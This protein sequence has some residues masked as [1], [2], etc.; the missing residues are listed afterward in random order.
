LVKSSA[1][2]TSTNAVLR[3]KTVDTGN[4]QSPLPPG[5]SFFTPF[6]GETLEYGDKGPLRFG[7]ERYAKYGPVFKTNLWGGDLYMVCTMDLF[8]AIMA[9]DTKLVNFSVAGT[10]GKLQGDFVTK[11]LSNKDG[12]R[13]PFRRSLLIAVTNEALAGYMPSISKIALSNLDALARQDKWEL[14]QETRKWGMEFANSLLAGLSD[15][16]EAD[17]KKLRDDLALFFDGLFTFDVDLPGTPLRKAFDARQRLLDRITLSITNQRDEMLKEVEKPL[18]GQPKVRKNMLGYLIDQQLAAGETVDVDFLSGLALGVLQAGTDTSSSGF[19]GLMAIL[20][21]MPEVLHK[22]REEQEAVVAQYGPEYSKQALD[23]SRYLDACVR[24]AL[25]INS[26]GQAQF[27][28]VEREFEVGGFRFP[29]GSSLF[30]NT[31]TAHALELDPDWP[32]GAAPGQMRPSHMDLYQI[33][34]CFKPERWLDPNP[35]NRPSLLTFGH[36]P[37]TCLGMAL[38][39]L[40][41]KTLVAAMA[42]QYDLQLLTPEIEWQEFPAT[43]PKHDVFMRLVPRR[44]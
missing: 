29:V 1:S 12:A 38:Y 24:E 42:R 25:R 3:V 19:N 39:I 20:G 44:G 37:H 30:L 34:K 28:S 5:P 35:D 7:L 16:T 8:K 13:M 17:A 21:Q 27:R 9:E 31:L 15:L 10:F 26:P 36:G 2:A 41:A 32:A 23:A 11:I 40:E 4:S 22:I 14:N 43:R 6:L 18:P 33:Q